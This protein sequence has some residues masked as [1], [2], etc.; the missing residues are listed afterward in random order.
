[1]KTVR[2]CTLVFI[3]ILDLHNSFYQGM[4]GITGRRFMGCMTVIVGKESL[5]NE[6]NPKIYTKRFSA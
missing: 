5:K 3:S 1:M 6:E 2:V 4:K